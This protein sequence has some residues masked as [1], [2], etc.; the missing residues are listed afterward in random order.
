MKIISIVE[1]IT[2]NMSRKIKLCKD[3][4]DCGFD[5]FKKRIIEIKEGITVLVG[6]NG[7]GKSTLLHYIEKTLDKKNIP[8]VK[9]DNLHDGGSR[10]KEKSLFNDDFRFFATS[11]YSS[12]GENIMLNMAKM[13][14]KI[15]TFLKTGKYKTKESELKSFLEEATGFE[16]DN[17]EKLSKERWFLF[18]AVDSG[19]SID[20]IVDL[21]EYLFKPVFE[22]FLENEIY[23]I[24]S[25][26]G[27]EMAN[28]EQCLDVYNGRYVTFNNYDE[29]RN[30]ILESRRWKEERSK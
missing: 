1:R 11:F 2:N 9:F 8:Y 5:L 29:Y 21:K 6:C 23:I 3:P 28:G 18:D 7:I 19:L 10:A 14:G 15:G 24:I 12:E 26:N 4:Y 16:S 22:H 25:A 20:N 30:M 27:Y 13:L 17:N